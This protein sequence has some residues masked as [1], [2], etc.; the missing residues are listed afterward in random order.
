MKQDGWS[1]GSFILGRSGQGTEGV[2]G[3]LGSQGRTYRVTSPHMNVDMIGTLSATLKVLRE[4]WGGMGGVGVGDEEQSCGGCGEGAAQRY[5]LGP[6]PLP[7][8]DSL[9]GRAGRYQLLSVL[10]TPTNPTR[11]LKDKLVQNCL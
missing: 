9:G 6:L 8:G 7:W 11:L 1:D 2:L 3:A 4:V 5:P 10:P